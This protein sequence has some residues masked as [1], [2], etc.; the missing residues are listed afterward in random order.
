VNGQ[1]VITTQNHGYAID[2]ST[3]PPGW[4]PLFVNANDQTNEVSTCFPDTCTQEPLVSRD[5][6]SLYFTSW[7]LAVRLQL[8][9]RTKLD[10]LIIYFNWGSPKGVSHY[11]HSPYYPKV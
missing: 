10:D 8:V 9:I 2:S 4:K 11:H 6:L 3:L 5:S 7:K 1:A